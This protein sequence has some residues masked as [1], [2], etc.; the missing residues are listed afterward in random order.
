MRGRERE[1]EYSTTIFGFWFLDSN[2]TAAAAAAAAVVDV[3]ITT[4]NSGLLW[5]SLAL[6]IFNVIIS[7]LFL[8]SFLLLTSRLNSFYFSSYVFRASKFF[9]YIFFLEF[10]SASQFISSFSYFYHYFEATNCVC[11]LE[12][13]YYDYDRM[14]SAIIRVRGNHPNDEPKKQFFDGLF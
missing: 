12:A 9:F 11:H 5:C 1:R 2:S 8:S 14:A 6:S 13:Q 4:T 7:P 3:R 10:S